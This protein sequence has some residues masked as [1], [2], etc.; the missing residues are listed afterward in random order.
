VLFL[1]ARRKRRSLAMNSQC[2]SYSAIRP[3]P[4]RPGFSLV[5]ALI[6]LSIM[7]M[8]GAVLLLSVESSLE[9]TA[10]AVDR[11]IADGIAQQMLDQ[12]LTKK[13]VENAAG[14]GTLADVLAGVGAALDE[15]TG[16]GTEL[17]DDV[18]DYNGYV[19]QPPKDIYGVL[20]GTGNDTGGQRP[21]N[22]RAPASFLQNWRVRVQVYFV[23]PND[24]RVVSSSATSPAVSSVAADFV[25]SPG[26]GSPNVEV[27]KNAVS[28]S[29]GCSRLP[30]AS[31]TILST[32]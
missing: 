6:A 9:N 10:D 5:E 32:T 11:T 2:I 12:I 21:A 16:G 4:R 24:H 29:P 3:R 1:S 22:F 30:A 14:G 31:A 15:L 13:F 28:L 18:D 20:L 25:A 7:A 17:Y 26:A 27:P 19:A 23:N 8:A